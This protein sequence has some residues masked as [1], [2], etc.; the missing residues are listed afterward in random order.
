MLKA[1]V[2]AGQEPSLFWRLTYREIGVILGGVS[3]RLQREHNERAWAA[4]H[5]AAMSRAKKMPKLKELLQ[6]DKKPTGRRMTPE[7]IEAV[8]RSWLARRRGGKK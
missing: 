1:W 8:T 2:G 4:W 5:I 7:Q 6:E 3:L